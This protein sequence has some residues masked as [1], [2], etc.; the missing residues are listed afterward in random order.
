MAVAQQRRAGM[1]QPGQCVAAQPSPGR[2]SGRERGAFR[3]VGYEGAQYREHAKRRQGRGIQGGSVRKPRSARRRRRRPGRCRAPTRQ[4]AT[5]EPAERR[6]AC[7]LF[8]AQPR[9]ERLPWMN[10][11]CAMALSD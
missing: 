1:Q 3:Q 10:L 4:S 8:V 11:T 6:G 5:T 7:P 9:I 2:R